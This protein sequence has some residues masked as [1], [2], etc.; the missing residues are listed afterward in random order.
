MSP[1]VVV[2]TVCAVLVV[3]VLTLAVLLT[4]RVQRHQERKAGPI[5]D[6]PPLRYDESLP[7]DPIDRAAQIADDAKLARMGFGPMTRRE[8]GEPRPVG[9]HYDVALD[10]LVLY[11]ADPAY[12]VLTAAG[13]KNK[14]PR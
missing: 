6:V 3:I 7:T 1:V 4:L 8:P 11:K 9:T 5:T 12:V 2:T 14:E 13:R 10:S